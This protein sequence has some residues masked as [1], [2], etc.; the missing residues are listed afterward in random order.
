ML[1][2][3][4]DRAGVQTD[5]R[6]TRSRYSTASEEYNKQTRGVLAEKDKIAWSKS[7]ASAD[8]RLGICFPT[9]TERYY[10]YWSCFCYGF[11]VPAGSLLGPG[12]AVEGELILGL[13]HCAG[14]RTLTMGILEGMP[15]F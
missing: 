11:S 13:A 15:M 2:Q 1:E 4:H 12:Q 3:K 5:R 10:Y 9:G 6:R 14:V 7:E 8:G